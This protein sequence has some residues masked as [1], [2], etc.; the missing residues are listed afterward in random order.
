[1]RTRAWECD[2]LRKTNAFSQP[3]RLMDMMHSCRL[4][5]LF[6]TEVIFSVIYWTAQQEVQSNLTTAML[7]YDPKYMPGRNE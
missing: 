4:S 5:S 1:M 3:L 2:L 6:C 7:F